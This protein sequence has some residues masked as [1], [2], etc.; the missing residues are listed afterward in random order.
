ML[1]SGK[2]EGEQIHFIVNHWSSR[3]G[4]EEKSAPKRMVSAL[5]ARQIVDDLEAENKN[6]KIIL[7]GDFNDEPFNE[8]LANGLQAVDSKDL[9][10]KQLFNVFYSLQKQGKGTYNYRGDWNMLDQM[11]ISN[12]LLTNNAKGLNYLDRAIYDAEYLKEASGKYEGNPFRMYVG[13]KYLGGYSDHFP[14][15][16]HLGK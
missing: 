3:G 11:I 1:V 16:V 5:V 13:T 6:A 8:S 15:Y 10:G 4:G 14:V 12:G 2:L 7:M 9:Q